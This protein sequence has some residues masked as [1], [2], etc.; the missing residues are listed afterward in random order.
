MSHEIIGSRVYNLQGEQLGKIKDL[1]L[2]IDT[3]SIVYAVLDF[4]G[5]MGIGDKLFLVP[6]KSLATLPSEGIFYLDKSKEQ[7]KK[8]PG[9]GKNK[10]PDIGDVRWGAE[11]HRHYHDSY[12][13]Y[14]DSGYGYYGQCYGP[15][16]DQWKDDPNTKIFDPNA[17][18]TIEGKLVKVEPVLEPVFGMTLELLVYTGKKEIQRVYLGPCR[19]ISINQ[20]RRFKAGDEVTVSGSQVTRKNEPYMIATTLKCRNGVLQLRNNDGIP[21]WVGWK[22]KS[23]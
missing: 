14:N 16:I 13:Y 10:A 4:G 22:K 6:W 17:I 12:V 7:L 9:F 2:D 3:G 5:F 11:I 8:A 15:S 20:E 18:T 19:Y 23:D 1:A 21:A